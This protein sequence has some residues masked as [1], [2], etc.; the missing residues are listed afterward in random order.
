[1][2]IKRKSTLVCPLLDMEHFIMY[3]RKMGTTQPMQSV[4][5]LKVIYLLSALSLTSI[6][7]VMCVQLM[8]VKSL[9]NP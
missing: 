6:K 3:G 8:T 2:S 1:M 7:E 4:L 5:E 9:H